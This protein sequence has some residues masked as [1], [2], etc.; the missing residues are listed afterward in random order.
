MRPRLKA[1]ATKTKNFFNDFGAIVTTSILAPV[2]PG[3]RSIKMKEPGLYI[4]V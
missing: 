2:Y 4:I 3:K 1:T